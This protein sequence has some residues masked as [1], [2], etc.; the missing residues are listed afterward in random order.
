M[1]ERR[2]ART[3]GADGRT[4]PRAG[5][6]DGRLAIVPRTQA[7]GVADGKELADGGTGRPGR[8]SCG[9]RRSPGS[10]IRVPIVW[11][12]TVCV[13]TAVSSRKTR[14]SA[15]ASMATAMPRRI[16]QPPVDDVRA[17]QADRANPMGARR[18]QGVPRDKR[19]IKSTYASATPVTDGRIV[20]AWF[21]SQGVHTFDVDGRF[22]WKVDLGR[23]DLAPTTFPRASGAPP[24]RR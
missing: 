4:L 6:R 1:P 10:R 24:A 7:S 3:V 21:G 2:V 16:A 23:I 18:T 14:H 19:H 9:A 11:G 22:L 15:P 12:D 20:V 5:G 8:T 13:P 17:R